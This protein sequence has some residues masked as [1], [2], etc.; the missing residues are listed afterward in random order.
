MH[1]SLGP[2]AHNANVSMRWGELV[3]SREVGAFP[4]AS[5]Q[6]TDAGIAD[7]Q[8]GSGRKGLAVDSLLHAEVSLQQP[9]C[10]RR[11]AP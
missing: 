1:I 4:F 11:A 9:P 10:P 5:R 3:R 7:I 2:N 8:Y 6:S